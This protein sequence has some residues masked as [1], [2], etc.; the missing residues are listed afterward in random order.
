ME[1]KIKKSRG[2]LKVLLVIFITFLVG[3]LAYGGIFYWHNL[4]GIWTSILPAKENIVTTIENS[5]NVVVNQNKEE[6]FVADDTKMPLQLPDG[7]SISL[8]AKDLGSPRVLVSDPN[9]NLIVSLTQNGKVVA[10]LDKDNNSKS[11]E[12]KILA[13]HLNLPHGLAFDC[14]DLNKCKLY[15]A[16]S[17]QV[18]VYDYDVN[19]MEIKNQ[20]KIVDLPDKGEHFTRTLLID[21]KT[22]RLLIS[23][24]SDCNVCNEKDNKRASILSANLDGTDLK[25]YASGLRNSV[26]MTAH[27]NTGA[28]YAD[29]MGRDLLG[30]NLPPDEINII[31]ENKKYGWPFCYGKNVRD[32]N[33]K[34]NVPTGVCTEPDYSPSYINIQAHS[35]P[36]GLQFVP[37][38]ESFPEDARNDLVVA[39]HGS[40]NRVE[41]TG[42]KVVKYDMDKD[43]NYV[44][45]EKGEPKSSDFI[46]G[47]L[48]E[49]KEALGRPT[50]ILIKDNGVMYIADDKAGVIYRVFYKAK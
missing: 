35:A 17:N 19:K 1:E 42:Y 3:G 15:I 49:N 5:E 4:R 33:F 31:K 8:Y 14:K 23:V 11:E 29:E 39:Y 47:W 10:L 22:N 50:G 9:G 16:E 34:E 28:I 38:I 2:W 30:D 48:T 6:S 21:P 44:V 26:F 24:G 43:G 37:D 27:P 25:I 41:P 45:D 7:F 32:N 18:S 13:D 46:S 20:R 36:L 12:T 40:W